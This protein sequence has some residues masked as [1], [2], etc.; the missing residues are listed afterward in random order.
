M[1]ADKYHET[2][3]RAWLLAVRHFMDRLPA[4]ESADVFIKASSRL[5]ERDVMLLHYSAALL[6][7]PRA[8]EVFVEPDRQ[9]IPLTMSLTR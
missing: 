1:D 9:P 5:R 2:L 3:T 4:C 6:F 7:S 8:R